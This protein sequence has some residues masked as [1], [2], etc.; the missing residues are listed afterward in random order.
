MISFL[1]YKEIES[2]FFV[3]DRF[4]FEKYSIKQNNLKIIQQYEKTNF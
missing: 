3:D 1:Q 4:S 2:L